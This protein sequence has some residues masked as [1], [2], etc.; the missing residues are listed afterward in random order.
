MPTVKIGP[1]RM[2]VRFVKVLVVGD[3]PAFGAYSDDPH[4]IEL[5]RSLKQQPTQ[6]S[7]ILLHEVIEGINCIH[8]VNLTHKQ[9]EQ[10]TTAL[11]QTIKDSKYLREML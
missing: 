4:L 6:L 2:P 7:S 8:S 5:D 9:I 3:K 1:H 10:L 11:S